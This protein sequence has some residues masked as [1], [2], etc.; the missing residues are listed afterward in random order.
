MINA[1][2]NPATVGHVQVHGA[3]VGTSA[4]ENFRTVVYEAIQGFSANPMFRRIDEG[5]LTISDYHRL[6]LVIFHQTFRS[7]QSF[8]LAGAM[9]ADVH[10]DARNYLIRH[11][12]E[13][14]LHWQWALSDLQSTGYPEDPREQPPT[15]ACAAYIGFNY[16]I[17]LR[18]PLAR[19]AIAAVLEGLGA[20]Y[21]ARYAAKAV[22]LLRLKPDQMQFFLGHAESDALHSEEILEV[23]GRC[24][25]TANEWAWMSV[26]ATTAIKLYSAMYE[27]AIHVS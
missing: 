12:Q 18:F 11:S 24:Q 23:I 5:R 15:P 26:S 22:S 17:A 2:S 10:L 1:I 8:A 9:V 3:V 7:P 21:S 16:F 27:E 25:L 19:L 13:E 14:L 4:M 20:T 6:L